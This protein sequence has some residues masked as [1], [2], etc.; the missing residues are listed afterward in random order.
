MQGDT[1]FQS[2]VYFQYLL[3]NQYI[4]NFMHFNKTHLNPTK[5]NI[6]SLQS[7]YCRYDLH[8]CRSST[9][10]IRCCITIHRF[11]SAGGVGTSIG[12]S[13]CRDRFSSVWSRRVALDTPEAELIVQ[14][15]PLSTRPDEL[16]TRSWSGCE[17]NGTVFVI[18]T[19][20]C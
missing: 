4:N 10:V 11:F 13:M 6:I 9:P 12:M 18:I 17:R 16:S 1:R 20:I 8:S 5:V 7:S 15:L 2:K 19:L 3:K 14:L